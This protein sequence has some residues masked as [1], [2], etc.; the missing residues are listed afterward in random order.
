[1]V[2]IMN[3][4]HKYQILYFDTSNK[5][6]LTQTQTSDI[7]GHLNKMSKEYKIVRYS[8]M[9]ILQHGTNVPKEHTYE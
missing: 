9:N 1:M 3:K 5:L 6:V 8:K 2:V 4:E 7:I